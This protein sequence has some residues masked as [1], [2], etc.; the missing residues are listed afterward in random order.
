MRPIG[1]Y[2]GDAYFFDSLT[3]TCTVVALPGTSAGGDSG[4]CTDFNWNPPPDYL[5][6]IKADACYL[7]SYWT[8]LTSSETSGWVLR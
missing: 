7:A 5:R 1:A 2:Q 4:D 6:T 3:I 8:T